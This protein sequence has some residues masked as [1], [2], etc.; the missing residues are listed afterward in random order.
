MPLPNV[1]VK[2]R[3]QVKPPLG[4]DGTANI[5]LNS[6]DGHLLR[7]GMIHSTAFFPEL[8]DANAVKDSLIQLLARYPWLAGRTRGPI[9]GISP[10]AGWKVQGRQGVAFS[11]CSAP[12]TAEQAFAELAVDS[13]RNLCNLV[14]LRSSWGFFWGVSPVM[15]VRITNFNDG[16]SALAVAV[17]AGLMDWTGLQQLLSEWAQGHAYEQWSDPPLV[18]DRDIALKATKLSERCGT[19]LCALIPYQFFVWGPMY[20][21]YWAPS[22]LGAIG[23]ILGVL[24][25]VLPCI[26]SLW[27]DPLARFLCFFY[28]E[29]LHERLYWPLGLTRS[30][31]GTRVRMDVSSEDLRSIVGIDMQQ[32]RDDPTGEK[33]MLV[34]VSILACMSKAVCDIFDY[35]R[36]DMQ[37]VLEVDTRRVSKEKNLEYVLPNYIGCASWLHF[38]RLNIGDRNPSLQELHSCWLKLFADSPLTQFTRIREFYDSLDSMD[39]KDFL[40]NLSDPFVSCVSHLGSKCLA[41]TSAWGAG[42]AIGVMSTNRGS[43]SMCEVMPASGGGVSLY[44]N[45]TNVSS[46]LSICAQSSPKAWVQRIRA[47]D[48]LTSYLQQVEPKAG[49]IGR[50]SSA[51]LGKVHPT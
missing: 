12:F 19:R 36:T 45:L 46:V 15:T 26:V 41:T 23:Y 34:E 16:G 11:V 43:F 31:G 1:Q 38:A 2:E 3:S 10:V 6:Y 20:L 22:S 28:I 39:V 49:T 44:F 47:P 14:D 8:L 29:D 21:S 42:E 24:F 37:L 18:A 35:K 7:S 32:A 40:V 51:G 4:H 30:R 13:S 33:L 48:F 5:R 17:C 27:P 50:R 9:L 25:L